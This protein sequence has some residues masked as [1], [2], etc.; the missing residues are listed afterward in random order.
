[1]LGVVAPHFKTM[2]QGENFKT[3]MN[4]S[5]ILVLVGFF[6][7]AYLYTKDASHI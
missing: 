1:V 7:S 4:Y 5:Q 6:C 2:L 3:T